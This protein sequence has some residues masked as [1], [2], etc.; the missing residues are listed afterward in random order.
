M[1]LARPRSTAALVQS[2]SNHRT[3]PANSV[4][5]TR[6]G[7]HAVLGQC[8]MVHVYEVGRRLFS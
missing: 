3:I 4:E 8:P 6:S 1:R 2:D 5:M 7:P